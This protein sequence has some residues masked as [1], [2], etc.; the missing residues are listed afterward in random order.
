MFNESSGEEQDLL[1][2]ITMRFSGVPPHVMDQVSPVEIV[3]G[4]SLLTP[5]LQ[6]SIRVHSYFHNLPVKNLDS[7]KSSNVTLNLKRLLL[8]LFNLPDTMDVSQVVYRVDNRKLV[9]NVTEEFIIHACDQTLLNDASSLVSKSWKCTTPSEV[10][11]HVLRS[12]A[13]ADK[14]DIESSDPARDYIAENIHP[15]QVVAQQANVALASGDD[16]SFLHYMTY[17]NLGTH[18]FRSLNH[19]TKQSPVMEFFYNEIG[20]AGDGGYR[21]PHG[22]MTHSFPCD[23]DL[24]SDILNGVDEKGRD[25]SSLTVYN[26]VNATFSLLGNQTRGCGLGA[27]VVK[28]AMTNAGSETAQNSCPDYAEAYLLK[29]QARMGLLEQDK[30][31]LRLTVPWNPVLHAGKVIKLSLHNKNDPTLLNYGSGDY[32]IVSMTHNIKNNGF[33]TTTMDCVSKTVGRGIV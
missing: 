32:L 21:N 15:F 4:E 27:A 3:L 30:I 11:N 8:K 19:L 28:N 24:L 31:A 23:F 22:I 14:L 6:T 17:E 1:T 29:R 9:N 12:C 25:I 2:K 26:P 5:G 33:S 13:G 7:F 16:P 10:V 20:I 18:H